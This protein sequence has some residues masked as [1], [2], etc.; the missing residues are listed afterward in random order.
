MADLDGKEVRIQHRGNNVKEKR[1]LRHYPVDG[2]GEDPRTGMKH[3]LQFYGCY[4]HACPTCYPDR[5]DIHPHKNKSYQEIYDDVIHVES[6]LKASDTQFHTIWEHV[7]DEYYKEGMYDEVPKEATEFIKYSDF[8]YGGRTEV[9]WP[10]YKCIGNEKIRYMDVTSLY[11]TVCVRDPLPTGHPIIIL[12]PNCKLEDVRN[13]TIFGVVRCL[14]HC[15]TELFVPLLPTRREDGR[16][17]FDLDS[18]KQ[19]VWTTVDLYFALDNGYEVLEVYETHHFP[20]SEVS[21]GLFRGY[22]DFFLRTKIECD[23]WPA[24]VETKEQKD[25]YV[26]TVWQ[27]NGGIGCIRPDKVEKNAGLRYVSKL[28]L[29]SLWGKFIQH[30][31]AQGFQFVSTPKQF[32]EMMMNP[33]IDKKELQ[34]M[35]TSPET[36]LASYKRTDD[37]IENARR[38]N[39]YLGAFVTAHARRRLHEEMKRIGFTRILYCDT[40]S[41]IYV[42][43]EDEGTYDTSNKPGLGNWASELEPYEEQWGT[44]FMSSGPKS[45]CLM[46]NQPGSDENTFT[47]KQKGLTL[48]YNNSKL[49]NPDVMRT[50]IFQYW[51]NEVMR[52]CPMLDQFTIRTRFMDGSVLVESVDMKKKFDIS[53]SKRDVLTRMNTD[54]MIPQRIVSIPFHY[55]SMMTD[56]RNDDFVYDHV[57]LICQEDVVG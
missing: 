25:E 32:R 38:Y 1:I 21:T 14:V 5:T 56:P 34:F 30:P 39:P 8:I 18:P 51:Q 12:A 19:G 11:P 22:M 55:V 16:L 49:L 48:N 41:I 31:Y 33:T 29:N 23:G 40:D 27:E 28:C 13:R 46:F 3:I 7:F 4:W 47:M 57:S 54:E 52:D 43:K 45:Y 20:P 10:Y 35:M 44:E 17:I 42:T 15:P 53:I 2:Y 37:F 50:C 6:I 26:S 24:G 9:F 36:L